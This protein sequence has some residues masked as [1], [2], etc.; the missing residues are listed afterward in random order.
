ME[1]AIFPFHYP[2]LTGIHVHMLGFV[3]ALYPLVLVLITYAGLEF[4]I[5][6]IR[7]VKKIFHMLQDVASKITDG[8]NLGN[9]II[10]AFA[11][12]ILLSSSLVRF[13]THSLVLSAAVF[14]VHGS[15]VKTVMY[16]DPTIERFS[17]SHIPYMFAALLLFFVLILCPAM[18]LTIYPTPL[19]ERLTR[20]VS[21]RKRIAFK[22]FADTFQES[23]KDGLNGT[24]DYRI[25]PGLLILTSVVYVA[26]EFTN[27]EQ[28]HGDLAIGF[29]WFLLSFAVSAIRPCK[30][31]TANV[32]L[33]FHFTL[34]GVLGILLNL[35]TRDLSISTETLAV[36]LTMLPL[37]PHVIMLVWVSYKV[38]ARLLNHFRGSM[39]VDSPMAVVRV[40]FMY[41]CQCCRYR[42]SCCVSLNARR[43][44]SIQY[45]LLDP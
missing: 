23:F 3:T 33:S 7:G 31:S 21:P 41:V 28:P 25:V 11:T 14:N 24:R 43:D 29:I 9:S 39:E 37:A 16:Y 42:E 38:V 4:N 2:K 32:S 27:V 40:V 45:A 12:F 19:Y 17:S 1:L 5:K 6:D 15:I 22:I 44:N 30:T 18:F 13:E 26:I 34:L 8:F 36:S 10:H 20:Y 35:W